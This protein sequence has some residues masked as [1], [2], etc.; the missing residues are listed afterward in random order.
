MYQLILDVVKL[1]LNINYP[2][3][4]FFQLTLVPDIVEDGECC[5]PECTV[6]EP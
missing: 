6:A 3:K 5:P 1:T 2:R 4:L